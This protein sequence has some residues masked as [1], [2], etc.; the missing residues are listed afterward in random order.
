MFPF[1]STASPPVPLAIRKAPDVRECRC[2]IHTAEAASALRSRKTERAA[3]EK[4]TPIS[5]FFLAPAA[6][7][8]LELTA[9]SGYRP[10]YLQPRYRQ[11]L[12]YQEAVRERHSLSLAGACEASSKQFRYAEAQAGAEEGAPSRPSCRWSSGRRP[13]TKGLA[14]SSYCEGLSPR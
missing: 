2:G 3:K 5:Q 10:G 4:P 1:T 12:P 11:S 14:G 7:A 13:R 8:P 6:P 9:P